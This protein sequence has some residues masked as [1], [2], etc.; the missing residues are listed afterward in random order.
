[1]SH[2]DG[3]CESIRQ[4][5]FCGEFW[6]DLEYIDVEVWIECNFGNFDDP[7]DRTLILR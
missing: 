4:Q 1:M 6:L 5:P 7:V 2:C 3:T